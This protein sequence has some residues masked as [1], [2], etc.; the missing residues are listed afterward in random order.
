MNE[1][2]IPRCSRVCCRTG[3]T[4][5]PGEAYYSALIEGKSGL[6]R[7]DFSAEAWHKEKLSAVGWWH[8]TVPSPNEKRIRL[9]ANDI[10]LELFDQWFG[11]PD[12][13][14]YLYVLTLLMIRRKIFRFE[15][16]EKSEETDG[17]TLIVYSARRETTYDVPS[18]PLDTERIERVQECL[19][20]LIYTGTAETKV[21]E[22][23]KGKM[24][25]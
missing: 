14:E 13:A 18:V 12:K 20:S 5:A 17:S 23:G 11:R 4:L 19:A 6:E 2:D 25:N 22:N 8:S 7:L 9:A 10:L 15:K 16:E 1:N 21:M 24:E 3:R